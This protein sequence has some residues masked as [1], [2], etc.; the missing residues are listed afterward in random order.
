LA[1]RELVVEEHQRRVGLAYAFAQLVDLARAQ[2]R[3]RVG[4]VDLLRELSD[5]DRASRVCE[6]G[7]LAQVIVRE[8]TRAG[9]LQRGADE[10]RPFRRRRDDYGLSTYIRILVVKRLASDASRRKTA[11]RRIRHREVSDW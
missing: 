11:G 3:A 6:L 8:T 5:D 9:P 1:W 4:T 2:I 10:Q 7:E